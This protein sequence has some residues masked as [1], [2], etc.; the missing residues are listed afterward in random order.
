MFQPN[1]TRLTT[2]ISDTVLF[3]IVLIIEVG[4]A[5]LMLD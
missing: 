4:G 1:W 5:G 2:K 3:M